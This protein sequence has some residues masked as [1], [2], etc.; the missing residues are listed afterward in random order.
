MIKE[1]HKM[2]N[3][4]RK[5]AVELCL[6]IFYLINKIKSQTPLMMEVALNVGKRRRGVR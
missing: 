6:S 1:Q 2:K 3:E 4:F 5:N